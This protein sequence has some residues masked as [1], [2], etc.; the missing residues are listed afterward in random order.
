MQYYDVLALNW[1]EAHNVIDIV[2]RTVNRKVATPYTRVFT[3]SVYP[4]VRET[5]VY[6]RHR[7]DDIKAKHKRHKSE[8]H[9]KTSHKF[10]STRP[11]A[12]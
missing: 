9:L 4:T 5:R 7:A 3:Q 11:F 10:T 12:T 8:I 1:A 6:R 2:N